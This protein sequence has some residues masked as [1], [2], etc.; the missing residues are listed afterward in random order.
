M[1]FDPQ[2]RNLYADDGEFLKTVECP[3]ALRVQDLQALPNESPD[4]HC[5][6][7]DRTIRCADDLTDSQ[8]RAELEED[9]DLCIFATPQARHIVLLRPKGVGHANPNRSGRPVIGTARTLEAIIEGS[10]HGFVP[11]VRRAGPD[12]TVGFKC[13]LVQHTETGQVRA[14]DDYRDSRWQNDDG[15]K[16]VAPWFRLRPDR[17]FPYAAY[18]VP[19][20]LPLGHRV[21]IEDLIEDVPVYWSQ[22]DSNRLLACKATWV[23]DDFELEWTPPPEVM[24]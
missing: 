8:M 17:P 20:G 13:M 18:L 11:L 10:H 23:G 19:R 6:H 9:E 4:R 16:V 14:V 5:H 7:C 2:T 15:W 1:I 12:S 22:G 24:G 3:L 21:Y